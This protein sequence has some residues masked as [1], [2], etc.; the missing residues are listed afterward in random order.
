[1]FKEILISENWYGLGIDRPEIAV[2]APLSIDKM[3]FTGFGVFCYVE[4]VFSLI[5]SM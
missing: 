2:G 3:D 5:Y 4:T 1:M